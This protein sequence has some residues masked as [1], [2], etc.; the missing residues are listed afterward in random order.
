MGHLLPHT[1]FGKLSLAD[2][3]SAQ[4]M[5]AP[6]RIARA[7]ETAHGPQSSSLPRF[8][9][10]VGSNQ[11]NVPEYVCLSRSRPVTMLVVGGVAQTTPILA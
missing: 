6:A 5:P 7:Q 9:A 11:Q 4:T 10:W 8:P 3:P 2:T 1:A